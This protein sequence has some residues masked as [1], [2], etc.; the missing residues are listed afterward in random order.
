MTES[1]SIKFRIASNN[2]IVAIK[3]LIFTTLKEY[4]LAPDP[5][6]TDKDL[7]DIEGCYFKIGGYF[8]VCEHNGKIVG[9]WAL[10]P[11]VHNACELRKMY[12]TKSARGNGIGKMMM[13]R[14]ITKAMKMEFKRMEL[15]TASVLKDAIK[16]YEKFGFKPIQ[17]RHLASRCDQ[18]YELNL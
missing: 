3:D 12:L 17:G 10:S 11:L 1:L 9:T 14:A 13:D 5:D 16:M 2:D 7:H 15:E 6:V 18:A 8:E 4:G